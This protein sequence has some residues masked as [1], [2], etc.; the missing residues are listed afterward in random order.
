MTSQEILAWFLALWITVTAAYWLVW[1]PVAW[2][3][4]AYRERQARR[5]LRHETPQFAAAVQRM[6]GEPMGWADALAVGIVVVSLGLGLL[7]LLW[8]VV[9]V[10][11]LVA[12][13]VLGLFVT[14]VIRSAEERAV[15]VA[16][17]LWLVAVLGVA[18]YQQHTR[19]TG[20][21]GEIVARCPGGWRGVLADCDRD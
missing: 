19:P 18:L 2:L 13:V 1:W 7:G 16:V 5:Q 12:F 3:V 11:L 10:L 8:L 20:R 14:A 17:A 9:V 4:H 21:E 15:K 6:G